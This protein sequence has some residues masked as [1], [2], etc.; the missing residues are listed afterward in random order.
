MPSRATVAHRRCARGPL[1]RW[2][3]RAPLG[4]ALVLL[5]VVA[6]ASAQML[7][8]NDVV[9]RVNGVPIYRKTVRDVVQ[10]G[11]VMQDTEPDAAGL[12]RMADQALDSLIAL[13]LLYQ[14]SQAH[15]VAVSDAD[16][17]AEI[18]RSRSN[19]PNDAA[20]RAALKKSGMTLQDLR[21]DTR[22]TLAVTRWVE[23]D[24]IREVKVSP[25]DIRAFYDQ[26]REEFR[27]D[28]EVRASH[29]LVR[30][31]PGTSSARRT[32]ARQRADKLLAEIR[33]GADF[34][35]VARASS[36]DPVTAARGGDRGFF[37][38]GEM[39]PAF[40]AA[41]FALGPGQMSGVVET[42]YGFEIIKVTDRR[43][44]GYAPF[45]EAEPV[46][47]EVLFK[48]AR[49]ERQAAMVTELR[50]KAKIEKAESLQ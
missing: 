16:V 19:F 33:G 29:I 15:G 24:A 12:A 49:Q 1:P 30:V 38:R 37:S 14:D 44:A 47:R 4:A 42:R 21:Q 10:G 28:A 31:A 26:N 9:A 35:A 43:E 48:S 46:I 20:F 23:A 40:D 22:K 41:A 11:V 36:E 18:K 6:S 32:A 8:D 39:D 45:E 17:D 2:R 27:H 7:L 13:E 3:V 25:N 50:K 34:A 5:G